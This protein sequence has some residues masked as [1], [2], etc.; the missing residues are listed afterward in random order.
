M[1]ARKTIEG[2]SGGPRALWTKLQQ[3]N[4]E[5]EGEEHFPEREDLSVY[6]GGTLEYP[7][8]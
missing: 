8:K 4:T 5:I 2:P 1:A 3:W 6:A 7:A